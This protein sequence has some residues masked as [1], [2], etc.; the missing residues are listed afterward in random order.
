V[1]E[2]A[3]DTVGTFSWGFVDTC[4][5]GMNINSNYSETHLKERGLANWAW[6]L[7][8]FVVS[9]RGV[10]VVDQLETWSYHLVFPIRVLE[11]I[12]V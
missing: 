6:F 5:V 9:W 10:S 3:N 8:S 11:I 2:H 4:E 7:I 1:P 12:W